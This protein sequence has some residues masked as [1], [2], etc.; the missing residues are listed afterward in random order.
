MLFFTESSELQEETLKNRAPML[1][2]Y[3]DG[4]PDTELAALNALEELMDEL[5]HPSS[6]SRNK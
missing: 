5:Q 3:Y 6:K 2:K 1:L 4:K